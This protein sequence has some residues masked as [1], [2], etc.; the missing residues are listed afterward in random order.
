MCKYIAKF[1]AITWFISFFSMISLGHETFTEE[2]Y[3]T[4]IKKYELLLMGMSSRIISPRIVIKMDNNWEILLAC[5]SE[6]TKDELKGMGVSF[7]DSQIMLLNAMRLLEVKGE[8]LKTKMPI[9]GS[10]KT[11]SLRKK[12]RNLAVRIEPELRSSVHDLKIELRKVGHEANIY[13]ILFSYTLDELAWKPF[14]EKSLI[15]NTGITV[16]RPFWGGIFWAC[17]PPHEFSCGTN[18]MSFQEAYFMVNWSKELLEKMLE[19][20]YR[21]NLKM[22]LRDYVEYGKIVNDDLLKELAPYKIVDYSGS[23][24]IPIIEEK[25]D[26]KLYLKC[27]SMAMKVAQLFLNNVDMK[28]LI[29]EYKFYDGEKAVVVSYH[30][31]MWEYLAYL[32]EKGIINKPFAFSNPKEAGPSDIGAL[33]FIVKRSSK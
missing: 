16:K 6:K 22:L 19:G 5:L 24:A 14:F 30:E 12:M 20:I 27:K 25:E 17:Y 3:P 28:S 13:T 31:W 10:V 33:L 21:A 18:Q 1:L 29:E 8:R 15:K 23:L 4:D 7:V 26:N 32:E 11:R 2:D 9:L